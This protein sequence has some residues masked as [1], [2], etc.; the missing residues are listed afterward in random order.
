MIITT[1]FF[2]SWIV[3][4]L[5]RL[6]L[7]VRVFFFL[8]VF[9][10][11][12]IIHINSYS[13]LKTEIFNFYFFWKNDMEDYTILGLRLWKNYN[14]LRNW[15]CINKTESNKGLRIMKLSPKDMFM[16]AG[17]N[18]S[19]TADTKRQNPTTEMPMQH[20]TQWHTYL[21]M[22]HRQLKH[23][24]ALWPPRHKITSTMPF[25]L[26]GHFGRFP[27]IVPPGLPILL[28]VLSPWRQKG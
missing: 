7:H 11:V 19:A 25:G 15:Q 17:R 9:T 14:W 20:G 5:F 3:M 1:S 26:S 27:H 22:L 23:F 21:E 24:Y 6:F 4:C 18:M 10:T 16:H 8:D 12:V 2:S 28:S 13:V